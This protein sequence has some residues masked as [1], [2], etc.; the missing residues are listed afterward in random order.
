MSQSDLHRAVARVLG[1]SVEFVSRRGFGPLDPLPDEPDP[2][3][4]IVDWD[5]LELERN[6]ALV[7]QKQFRNAA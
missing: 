4:L 2:E 6:V 5:R 3:E 7:A 1:E